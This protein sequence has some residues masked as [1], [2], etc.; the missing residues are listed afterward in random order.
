ML[1]NKNMLQPQ[2][3][4]F[5]SPG[6]QHSQTQFSMMYFKEAACDAI[7]LHFFFSWNEL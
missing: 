1:F 7:F 3:A 2:S 6:Q 5:L 4:E